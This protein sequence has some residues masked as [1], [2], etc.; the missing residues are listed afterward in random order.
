MQLCMDMEV[1]LHVD[2]SGS[3]P[4]FVKIIRWLVYVA[5]FM[6]P[7]FFLPFTADVLEFNKQVL[8]VVVAGAGLLL[9]LV[10]IIRTGNIKYRGS[11]FYVPVLVLVVAAIV[12]VVF[13]VHRGASLFGLGEGRA[14]S[15]ISLVSL[16]FIFFLAIQVIEDSGRILKKIFI[17]S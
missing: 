8:L 11:I 1:N 7:L 5:A 10:D 3:S 14:D 6:T 2:T 9:Y 12:S 17:S 13:S 16:L 15:L 4:I